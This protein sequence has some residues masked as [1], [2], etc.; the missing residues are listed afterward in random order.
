MSEGFFD[1][2]SRRKQQ[3]R[4]GEV[5]EEPVPSGA[6]GRAGGRETPVPVQAA[7]VTP[8]SA[9][10]GRTSRRRRRWPTPRR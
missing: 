1:R 2:W 9:G 7:Q 8:P 3:V 6:G 5:P 10:R 4:E